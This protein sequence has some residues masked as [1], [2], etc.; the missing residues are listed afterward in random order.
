MAL[1]TS[2]CASFRLAEARDQNIA[3]QEEAARRQLELEQQVHCIFALASD[4]N[5]HQLFV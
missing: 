2:D 4:P 1:I 5:R 3:V